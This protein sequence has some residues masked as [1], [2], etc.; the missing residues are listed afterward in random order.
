MNLRIL[1]K[2]I[3]ELAES[4][5]LVNFSAAGTS[6]EQLNGMEIKWYPCLFSSPT[7][8]H[9]VMQNTTRYEITLY[10]IDRLLGDYS[11]DIDIFSSSIENLKNII[12]GIT[13]IPGVAEVEDNYVVRNF[14]NT[15]KMNDSLGGAYATIRIT[16]INDTICYDE[17]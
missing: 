14:A 2:S 3:G 7:G 5:K 17:R 10:Y 9:T 11:N 8:S 12:R 15:E 16:C 4:Q 1:L 6:M 13:E